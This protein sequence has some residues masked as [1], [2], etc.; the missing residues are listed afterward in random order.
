MK[1][2]DAEATGQ[3]D[4]SA[5]CTDEVTSSVAGF[6]VMGHIARLLC[7]RAPVPLT[8]RG[9][10]LAW[11]SIPYCALRTSR[12]SNHR[13]NTPRRRRDLA[14]LRAE[15]PSAISIGL[16]LYSPDHIDTSGLRGVSPPQIGCEP[17]RRMNCSVQLLLWGMRSYDRRL[18]GGTW[19]CSQ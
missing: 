11:G 18:R 19:K 8:E 9:H 12:F 1:L 10:L 2:P 16:K 13:R 17:D 4:T 7:R 15:P 3:T 5:V 14:E 6:T